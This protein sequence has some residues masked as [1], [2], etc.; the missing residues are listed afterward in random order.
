[1]TKTAYLITGVLAG[2]VLAGLGLA[3]SSKLASAQDP[4]KARWTSAS[5]KAVMRH[6]PVE[7]EFKAQDEER[8]RRLLRLELLRRVR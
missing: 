6:A 3:V 2:V 7:R 4:A 1:M 5:A 8:E